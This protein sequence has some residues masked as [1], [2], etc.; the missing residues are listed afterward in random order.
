MNPRVSSRAVL[1]EVWAIQDTFVP[2]SHPGSIVGEL[3]AGGLEGSLYLLALCD[4]DRRL[5]V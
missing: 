1:S 4:R 2:Q 3:D 5:S